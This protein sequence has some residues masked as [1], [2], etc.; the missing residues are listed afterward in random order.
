[1]KSFSGCNLNYDKGLLI[2]RKYT[3]HLKV[4]LSFMWFLYFSLISCHS[5]F[6]SQGLD[7]VTILE[8]ILLLT[9]VRIQDLQYWVRYQ[10]PQS[11]PQGHS[12]L[13][14]LR[15]SASLPRRPSISFTYFISTPLQIY[16]SLFI[17][18]CQKSFLM[19]GSCFFHLL[20][21]YQSF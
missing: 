7:S 6:Q 10:E 8:D 15:Q 16:F 4:T 1:M 20:K 14:T 21:S 17:C 18:L 11:I 13:Q 3:G 19:F 2:S 9:C 5:V 12:L